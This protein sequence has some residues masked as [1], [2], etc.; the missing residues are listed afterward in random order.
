MAFAAFGAAEVLRTQPDHRPSRDLLRAAANLIGRPAEGS[1]WPW[2]QPR[3]TY[4]NA[5]LPEAP[6]V[7]GT[8]L[9][10]PSRV[11]DGLYLHRWLLDI[12]TREGRLSVVPVCGWG[13][14]DIGAGPGFDQQPIEVAALADACARVHLGRPP[15]LGRRA[16]PRRVVVSRRQRRRHAPH[17][18]DSGGYDGLHARG[19][20]ENQGA[21]STLAL[22]STLQHTQP[23]P[24]GHTPEP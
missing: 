11:A 15:P 6:I 9:E 5:A 19:R 2:P 10:D 22:L 16:A 8:A 24:A 17:D 12:Q 21:E 1:G 4:A 18:P 13:P 3:L 7:A 20:N 23:V 14:A